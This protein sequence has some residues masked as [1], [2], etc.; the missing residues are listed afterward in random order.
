ME[1]HEAFAD[2]CKALDGDGAF[3]VVQ[4]RE[5]KPNPMTIGWGTLGI[6]W[7]QPILTVL[8]RPSRH[9]FGLIEGAKH[10][11]V[12]VPIK[13]MER[14]LEF[15]GTH[16]GRDCDKMKACG[17]KASAGLTKGVSVIEG[18]G[19]VYE[20]EIVHK[21]RVQGEALDPAIAGKYYPEGDFHTI[22]FGKVQQAYRNK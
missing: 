9:T 16:S 13:G 19:L 14:E 8:V 6:V 4:D 7:S 18:C 20:C 10:F 21:T 12:C 2:F 1:F 3:L 11:S 5:G 22:Y 15:C 17:L